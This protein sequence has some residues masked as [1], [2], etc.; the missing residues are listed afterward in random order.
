[1]NDEV[2]LM[3]LDQAIYIAQLWRAGKMIGWDDDMVRNTLLAEVERV[4]AGSLIGLPVIDP[5]LM[6]VGK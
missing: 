6:E 3:P 4:R 1:M 2:E 5:S